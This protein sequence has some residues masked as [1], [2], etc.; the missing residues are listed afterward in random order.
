VVLRVKLVF[1]EIQEMGD[2][3]CPAELEFLV[4]KSILKNN[5]NILTEHIFLGH[6]GEPGRAGLNGKFKS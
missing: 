5:E 6:K 4:N 2:L 1:L 3:V